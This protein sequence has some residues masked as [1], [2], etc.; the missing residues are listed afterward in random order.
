M[1]AKQHQYTW[2]SMAFLAIG[3]FD[4]KYNLSAKL[5]LLLM[6][7]LASWLVV[8]EKV[9]L[10]YLGDF[11]GYGEIYLN[12]VAMGLFTV[13]ATVGCVT[14]FNMIDG[15]D[16]LLGVVALVVLSSLAIVFQMA[17]LGAYVFFCIGFIIATL[18]YMMFNLRRNNRYKVFMG[19]AG[20]AFIG[21]SVVWLLVFA[22]QPNSI[23]GVTGEV[24]KPVYVLWLI[25]LPLMDM[26]LVML[27]RAG[28]GKSPIQ[29]DRSHVHHVLLACGIN[30]NKVL[31]ILSATSVCFAVL[32][33]LSH[34]Y[35][36]SEYTSFI[37]F[38]VTFSCYSVANL[39]LEKRSQVKTH[40]EFEFIAK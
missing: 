33:I 36:L 10:F 18:P 3:F 15:L 23:L 13:L 12:S 1:F 29:A 39:W 32:G 7:A 40:V 20:S 22:T 5:R 38:L 16:G 17:G 25:A 11:L 14:A 4:D 21:F 37:T 2:L 8:V 24:I 31:M 30:P 28:R 27:K 35:Q 19:D 34:I 9:G 26:T 6:L